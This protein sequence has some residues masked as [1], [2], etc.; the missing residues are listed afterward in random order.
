M[1]R[2]KRKDVCNISIKK[3]KKI[4]S[5]PHSKITMQT[6]RQTNRYTYRITDIYKY[7][8]IKLKTHSPKQRT[9]DIFVLLYS[10]KLFCL[11]RW[12]SLTT[13]TMW[14]SFTVKL[15]IGPGKVYNYF[16]RG[17]VHTKR[18][19][20]QEQNYPSKYLYFFSF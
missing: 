18:K 19:S 7:I 11:Q 4:D 20:P 2:L 16:G 9:T 17:Y 10:S 6:Y 5:R 8:Y 13:E 12:I 3:E 15:F 1:N 14:F